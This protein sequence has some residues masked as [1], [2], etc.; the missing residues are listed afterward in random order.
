MSLSHGTNA[1][2]ATKVSFDDGAAYEKAKTKIAQERDLPF[3]KRTL[4]RYGVPTCS[5]AP[6]DIPSDDSD[7][8]SD[9]ENYCSDE[10]EQDS[11]YDESDDDE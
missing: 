10:S 3:A 6:N 2:N 4:F 11:D 7:N 1:W 9:A 5:L 8:E